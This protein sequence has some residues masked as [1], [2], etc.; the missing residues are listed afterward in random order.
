MTVWVPEVTG[1]TKGVVVVVRVPSKVNVAPGGTEVMPKSAGTGVEG[2][3]TWYTAFCG[4]RGTIVGGFVV[5]LT[6]VGSSAGLTA[7]AATG[8]ASRR[9]KSRRRHRIL[10]AGSIG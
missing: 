3:D 9:Q 2:K 5:I 6:T 1:M 7:I 4:C 10:M 8:P